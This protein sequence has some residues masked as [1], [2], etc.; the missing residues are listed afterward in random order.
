M[1]YLKYNPYTQKARIMSMTGDKRN[2]I[3]CTADIKNAVRELEENMLLQ[4]QVEETVDV[5]K[6]I[7]RGK[8]EVK[9]AGTKTDFDYL[10]KEAKLL[11]NYSSLSLEKDPTLFL[12]EPKYVKEQIESICKDIRKQ[13]EDLN[14]NPFNKNKLS[15]DSSD[16]DE[17]LSDKTPL[18][19]LGNGSSGKSSVINALIGAEILPTGDGTTTE[20]LYEIR[21]DE[22]FIVSCQVNGKEICIDLCEP[23]E[24]VEQTLK[25]TFEQSVKFETDNKYDQVYQIV[26][27]INNAMMANSLNISQIKIQ[28]PF[29]NLNAIKKS[30]VIFDTPGPDA[31]I[32]TNHRGVLNNALK[33]FK[34]GVA[35]LVITNTE[36]EKTTMRGF[37][38]AN[39]DNHEEIMRVLNVNAGIVVINKADESTIKSIREAKESRKKHLNGENGE[40]SQN[41]KR[42]FVLDEDRMVYFSSPYALGVNKAAGEKWWNSIFE[43]KNQ[44]LDKFIDKGRV[45]FYRPLA[46]EAELPPLRK[47]QIE[48]AYMAA[49]NQ[50]QQ[51][52]SEENKRE[53]I[54][55]NSGLRALESELEFVVDKLSI[56]NLCEQARRQLSSVLGSLAQNIISAERDLGIK[57]EEREKEF[58]NKYSSIVKKLKD[59]ETKYCDE[60]K[61]DISKVI[62]RSSG[63]ATEKAKAYVQGQIEDH[64]LSMGRN[65]D[66]RL[67]IKQ[68]TVGEIKNYIKDSVQN[69]INDRNNEAVEVY[70]T[71]YTEFQN[72]CR[73]AVL[74]NDEL[75]NEEKAEL[76]RCI[77]EYK[78][79]MP[80]MIAFEEKDIT[81]KY[82]KIFRS[83][84]QAIENARSCTE[85]VL[86]IN[87]KRIM[88]SL[89]EVFEKTCDNVLTSFYTQA[90]IEE[91]NPKLKK[92]ND[93]ISMLEEQREA[94]QRLEDKVSKY[95]HTID[96]LTQFQERQGEVI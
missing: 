21:D 47:K 5:V 93:Q 72:G 81:R 59:V 23:Q 86:L 34:K 44:E 64:W 67:S 13:V 60:L 57:Q 26:S 73:D 40:N 51:N 3:I 96:G 56:C 9:F 24:A 65:K 12:G 70:Q 78:P 38:K 4:N 33:Q 37:L 66:H 69:T 62:E 63:S 30:I 6:G 7:E 54:A 83:K 53:L 95:V 52:P 48:E 61:E 19:F 74:E 15:F 88:D 68:H 89:S 20:T 58:E 16:V 8:F 35:V 41:E 28:L 31:G 43:E 71:V 84:K 11:N 18:V 39:T 14:S 85:N 10:S 90:K 79:I 1:V 27:A 45:Q 49:E 50:Y 77:I 29:K 80:K 25:N 75:S 94:F 36:I 92:L 2:E 17:T 42:F 22:S 87:A 76:E 55:H 82:I 32:Q 91:R 46:T